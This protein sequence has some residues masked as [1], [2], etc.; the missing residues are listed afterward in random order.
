[1]VIG[2]PKEIKDQEYRI[3]MTPVGVASLCQMGHTIL[4]E[5]GAGEGSGFSDEDFQK[6]GAEIALSKKTLFNTAD[7]IIK[8][9]E[10]ISVEY[11]FFRDGQILFTFLHLAADR[12]LLDFLLERGI[13]A[14]AYE[15]I[16]L[17]D[18]K[19][20][21]LKPMSEVAG[22]MS[23]LIGAQYLRKTHGGAGILLS[24]VAGVP[25]G[26]VGIIGGGIVGKNA[27]QVALALGAEVT[28]FE[29]SSLQRAYLDD[30]FRGRVVI[31]PPYPEEIRKNIPGCHLVVGAASKTG[32]KAPHLVSRDMVSK[33]MKG[34]VI[35]DVAID[36]GGCF[37]TSRKTS[38]SDPTYTVDDVVHYCV[39]NIPGIV[40]QTATFALAN[41]SFPYLQKLAELGLKE[42]T[43]Q[44]SAL[45]KGINV[46]QGKIRHAS[47]AEAFN[48]TMEN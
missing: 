33:M 23:V 18:G 11:D 8:V 27:A 22:R 31:L 30:F 19:R 45:R 3:S 47:V 7:L 38:H 41:E 34:S 2:V 12:P 20:P 5:S 40:P 21:L 24:G 36:Q 13:T 15:T 25:K 48:L 28:I 32:D 43:A 1:M 9:K 17:E 39:T 29:Q 4:L 16:E 42:A 46:D 14:I 44:D 26:R 37:E 6:A 10:P 35:V